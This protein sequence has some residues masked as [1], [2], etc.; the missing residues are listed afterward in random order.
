VNG[1]SHFC[2][3]DFAADPR[4]VMR[5]M[6]LLKI[7]F[8]KIEALGLSHD[9]F[10]HQAAMVEILKTK[11]EEFRKRIPFY[12]GEQFFVGTYSRMPNG[13]IVDL[14]ALKK[15]DIEGLG[16]VKVVEATYYPMIGPAR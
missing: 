9:H 14:L 8:A 3:F 10:D 6:K 2:L 13:Q 1:Q 4:G 11:K 12:V 15:E 5:N 7:D 16:F